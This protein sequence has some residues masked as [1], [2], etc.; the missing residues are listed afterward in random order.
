V[1]RF[2]NHQMRGELEAIRFE[3]WHELMVRT[4]LVDE[5]SGFLEKRHPSP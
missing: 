4:G 1:L 3:I 5:I 2:W